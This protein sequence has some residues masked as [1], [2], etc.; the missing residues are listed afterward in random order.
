MET[1]R[2]D[3][4]SGKQTLSTLSARLFITCISIDGWQTFHRDMR[5]QPSKQTNKPSQNNNNN[6][7]NK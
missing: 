7:D 2:F 4:T 6:N 1:K 3:K 5:R